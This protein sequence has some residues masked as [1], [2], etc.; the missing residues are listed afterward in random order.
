MNS[1]LN[2]VSEMFFLSPCLDIQMPV[3]GCN[4][5]PCGAAMLCH[6]LPFCAGQLHHGNLY[7]CWCAPNGLVIKVMLH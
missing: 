6:P 3:A 1:A 4:H 5:L 2:E 7:G